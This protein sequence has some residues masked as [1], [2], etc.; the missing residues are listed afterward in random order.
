MKAELQRLR[1]ICLCNDVRK[2]VTKHVAT[3]HSSERQ[4]VHA[5]ST[6]KVAILEGRARKQD[7]TERY[8]VGRQ[9]AGNT[10]ARPTERALRHTDRRN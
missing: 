8:L 6:F 10:T 2:Y 9:P 3:S 5:V 1:K 4:A 7:G